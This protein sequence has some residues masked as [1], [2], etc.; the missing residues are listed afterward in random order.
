MTDDAAHI[1][2]AIESATELRLGDIDAIAAALIAAIDRLDID[3]DNDGSPARGA[4]IDAASGENGSQV[5]RW[6]MVIEMATPSGGY[7]ICSRA[8][9]DPPWVLL[10]LA[11]WLRASLLDEARSSD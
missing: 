4:I 5:T 1:I 7:T 3:P 8:T 6:A 2:E 10:G 9:N 11:E